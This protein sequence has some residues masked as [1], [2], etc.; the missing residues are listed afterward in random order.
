VAARAA[1]LSKADLA[2]SMVVEITSLQGVMGEIYAQRSGEPE[3]VARAIREQ[4]V[5][6]PDRPMSSPGWR[7]TWPTGWIAWWPLCRGAGAT[8][9]ADPFGL[10]RAALGVVQN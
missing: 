2:T 8:S 4:Y 6:R 5:L 1:T 10:R 9:G 3:A 7:S